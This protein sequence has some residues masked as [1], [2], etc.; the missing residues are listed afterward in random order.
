MGIITQV[1]Q[2]AARKPV[3]LIQIPLCPMSGAIEG[4]DNVA[5]GPGSV[6]NVVASRI[7]ASTILP[8]VGSDVFIFY[9]KG[10]LTAWVSDPLHRCL[11]LI[12]DTQRDDVVAACRMIGM[13][14]RGVIV[15]QPT[16]SDIVL[17]RIQLDEGY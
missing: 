17:V 14:L 12:V 4:S 10:E 16:D 2:P 9:S 8:L 15:G 11:G 1:K 6:P 13:G 3:I 7:G 5:T